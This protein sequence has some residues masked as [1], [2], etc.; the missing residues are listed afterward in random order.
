MI[1]EEAKFT[2][3]ELCKKCGGACCKGMGCE[4]LPQDFNEITFDSLYNEI[5]KGFISI[6]WWE[7]DPRENRDEV[8]LAFYL[9]ARNINS[10]IVDASWGGTCV[11]WQH[12]KGC[13]L[14]WANR[15]TG[16]KMLVPLYDE[17]QEK[18][19]CNTNI[20]KREIVLEWLQY[21]L[22]LNELYMCFL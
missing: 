16:G 8:S 1:I 2:N 17:E 6:D 15:P 3:Y 7:G 21:N 4:Y 14:S 22:I 11:H 12:D 13:A 5:S 9:R 20:P 10:P 18:Y 19:S